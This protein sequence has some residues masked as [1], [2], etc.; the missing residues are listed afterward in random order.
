MYNRNKKMCM[1]ANQIQKILQDNN[2]WIAEHL[3]VEDVPCYW[4]VEKGKQAHEGVFICKKEKYTKTE[5]NG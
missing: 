3:N 5:S 4:L 2:F 1:A